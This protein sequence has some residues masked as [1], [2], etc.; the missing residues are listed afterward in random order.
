MN[1][2]W[3]VCIKHPEPL[4]PPRAIRIVRPART[5]RASATDL[6]ANRLE[7]KHPNPMDQMTQLKNSRRTQDEP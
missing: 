2:G 6:P 7:L 4:V 5:V 3:T 1:Q